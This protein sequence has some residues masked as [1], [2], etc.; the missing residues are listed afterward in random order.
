LSLV[1]SKSASRKFAVEKIISNEILIE[2]SSFRQSACLLS[3]VH[4]K[5]THNIFFYS[6]ALELNH[7]KAARKYETEEHVKERSVSL[8]MSL[9]Q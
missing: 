2:R 9:M 1:E 5:M 6:K 4:K 8:T 7:Y 3:F